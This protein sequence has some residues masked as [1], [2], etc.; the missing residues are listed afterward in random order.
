MVCTA[1]TYLKWEGWRCVCSRVVGLLHDS[2]VARARVGDAELH[3]ADHKLLHA[4]R[5]G[6]SRIEQAGVAE[7]EDEMM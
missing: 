1:L 5:S 3:W 7:Q 6:R 4:G 2:K